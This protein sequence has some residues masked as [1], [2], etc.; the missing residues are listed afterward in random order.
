MPL[1]ILISLVTIKMMTPSGAI[2][3]SEIHI[4]TRCYLIQKSLSR[5]SKTKFTGFKGQPANV[6]AP[7]EFSSCIDSNN[8]LPEGSRR[9]QQALQAQKATD[10]STYLQA[11]MSNDKAE[12]DK[13]CIS[14]IFNMFDKG[15]FK[16]SSLPPGQNA[17]QSTWV[18]KTKKAP[19]GKFITHKSWLY[20]QGFSEELGMSFEDTVAPTE[21]LS[22]L[23]MLL[24]KATVLDLNIGKMDAVTAFLNSDLTEDIF[25]HLAK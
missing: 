18:F 22:S 23:R 9:H 21:R 12:W 7:Q 3:F 25:M 16:Y 1:Q 4:L 17:I 24:T 20:K 13:A 2:I 10:P 8:I 19:N 15:V 6:P 14:K 5:K 11:I